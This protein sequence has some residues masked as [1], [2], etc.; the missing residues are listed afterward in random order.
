MNNL[1]IELP[2]I[3]GIAN[4]L[5]PFL[6]F[7]W[8]ESEAYESSAT[9]NTLMSGTVGA[10]SSNLVLLLKAKVKSPISD[11]H[12]RQIHRRLEVFSKGHLW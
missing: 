7:E 12:I 10:T 6:F 5:T 9:W 8:L 2:Y 3:N 4:G 11:M 1:A